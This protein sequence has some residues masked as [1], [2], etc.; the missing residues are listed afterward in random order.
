MLVLRE[1][2]VSSSSQLRIAGMFYQILLLLALQWIAQFPVSEGWMSCLFSLKCHLFI[3]ASFESSDKQ[4][5]EREAAY[6]LLSTWIEQSPASL[7][8]SLLMS[9]IAVAGAKND[10]LRFPS[11]HL[12]LQLFI[13]YPR[14]LFLCYGY[15][16]L[17]QG[18]IDTQNASL[19]QSTLLACLYF[20]SDQSFRQTKSLLDLQVIMDP[21]LGDDTLTKP[22]TPEDSLASP[23]YIANLAVLTVMRSWNGL[24]LFGS[25]TG[26]FSHYVNTLATQS[27]ESPQVAKEILSTLFT[28]LG[29]P[30]PSLVNEAEV[31]HQSVYWNDCSLFV[32]RLGFSY[33]ERTQVNV[34]TVYLALVVS[35][36]IRAKLPETLVSLIH[37]ADPEVSYL[38]KNLLS[39][40]SLLSDL[41]LPTDDNTCRSFIL[42]SLLDDLKENQIGVKETDF[43]AIGPSLLY[44][45]PIVEHTTFTKNELSDYLSWIVLFE[46]IVDT[47][48]DNSKPLIVSDCQL[49]DQR[50]VSDSLKEVYENREQ[51]MAMLRQTI[52]IVSL[53][54]LMF[55]KTVVNQF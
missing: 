40:L 28:L 21:L 14:S 52:V 4:L 36:C 39:V 49:L 17:L 55:R 15:C 13:A 24:L 11:L 3:I 7:P 33:S 22:N 37:H 42:K 46:N 8:R 48:S 44:M 20:L 35:V 9:I 50:F 32:D 25:E 41:S 23:Y 12:L 16:V 5:A 19:L 53:S 1:L 30:T 6:R 54:L 18:C 51:F 38:A 10:P 2:L 31:H 43:F 27:D 34:L 45:Y 29:I 47:I 26:G